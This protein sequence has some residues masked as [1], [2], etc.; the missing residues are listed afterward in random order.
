MYTD[1]LMATCWRGWFSPSFN[2]DGK[3]PA[4]TLSFMPISHVMGRQY[5]VLHAGPRRNGV[6]RRS[7]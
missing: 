4:I 2:P 3:L 5:S 6:L 1:R 7:Q